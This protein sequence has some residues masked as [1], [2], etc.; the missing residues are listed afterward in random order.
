MEEIYT[1]E[2]EDE[3]ENDVIAEYMLSTITSIKVG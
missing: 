3:N 1:G 2:I